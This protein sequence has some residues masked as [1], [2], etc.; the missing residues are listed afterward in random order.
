MRPRGSKSLKATSC[1]PHQ[2]KQ[3]LIPESVEA[4]REDVVEGFKTVTVKDSG[5]A[6]RI[7]QVCMYLDTCR[8]ERETKK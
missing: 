2:T 1:R 3:H 5:M 4:P 8:G 6:V 7:L